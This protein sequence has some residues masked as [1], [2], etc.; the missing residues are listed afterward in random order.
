[1]KC[2]IIYKIQHYFISVSVVRFLY[3]KYPKYTDTSLKVLEGFF[4][5]FLTIRKASF[6]SLFLQNIKKK[7]K[8]IN[9]TKRKILN[10]MKSHYILCGI[11]KCY[12]SWDLLSINTIKFYVVVGFFFFFFLFFFYKICLSQSAACH[13]VISISVSETVWTEKENPDALARGC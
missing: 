2:S 10:R 12:F 13:S 11:A 5:F 1:M 6:S 7:S 4:F 9:N 3:T 8:H